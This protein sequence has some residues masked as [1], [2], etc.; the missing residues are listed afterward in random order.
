MDTSARV[1]SDANAVPLG[2][3]TINP[4]DSTAAF[5]VRN[6]GVNTVRGT[7]PI[8]DASVVVA[9]GGRI[10]A[11]HAVLDLFGIDTSNPKRDRDLRGHRLLDTE[12]FPQLEFDAT[13]NSAAVDGW[14]LGGTLTCRGV[15]I[16]VELDATP[17]A[18]STNGQ[19]T[20][21]AVTRFDRRDLGIRAPRIMIGRQVLVEI[22]A[23]FRIS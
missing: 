8:R 20:V 22:T 19:M 13:D 7:V 3:W 11:V 16:P 23:T 18:R 2:R 4:A 12:Q 9:A 1:A 17:T 21:R 5:S 15:S 10:T 14:R 6:F